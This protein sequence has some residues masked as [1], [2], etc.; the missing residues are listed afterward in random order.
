[1]KQEYDFSK[2]KRGPVIPLPSGKL[3]ITIRLDQDILEW[4]KAR[5]DAAGDG[6][7]Q[8]MMNDAL[9]QFM[10]SERQPL[11][12]KH[13]APRSRRVRSPSKELLQSW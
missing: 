6:N 2:G 8:T 3:R 1:M 13:S 4:F 11:D 7:Y 5:V 12:G 10:M 9:R